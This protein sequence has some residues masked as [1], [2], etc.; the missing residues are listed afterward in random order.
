LV[1]LEEEDCEE[2]LIGV[3]EGGIE[4]VVGGIEEVVGG[5]EEVVVAG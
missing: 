3:V 1:E 4:E 2:S 5:I